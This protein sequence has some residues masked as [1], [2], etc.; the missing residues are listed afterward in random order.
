MQSFFNLQ[1]FFFIQVR[2]LRFY[3]VRVLRQ[4]LPL[5]AL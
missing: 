1:S 5:R 2:F 4:R 3:L